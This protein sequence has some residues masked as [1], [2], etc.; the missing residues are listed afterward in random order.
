M[1][2]EIAGLHT[3]LRERL[4]TLSE[5]DDGGKQAARDSTAAALHELLLYVASNDVCEEPRRALDNSVNENA[6]ALTGGLLKALKLC[7]LHRAFQGLPLVKE[8]TRRLLA[9]PKRVKGVA[10]YLEDA[11]C[12]DIDQCDD[13][14]ALLCVQEVHRFFIGVGMLKKEL[15]GFDLPAP[16]KKSCRTVVNR[17]EKAFAALERKNRTHAV[18]A[19]A[20]KPKVYEVEKDFRI[21]EREEADAQYNA[22][23]MGMD[24][25]FDK[26]VQLKNEKAKKAMSR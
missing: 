18:Q 8:Q 14:R 12:S 10:S 3:T 6:M 21:E 16:A 20:Q 2:A 15:G 7:K 11:L 1:D 22:L 4:T 24:A 26:A 19:N 17:A 23:A 25:M 5:A 9:D 13:P